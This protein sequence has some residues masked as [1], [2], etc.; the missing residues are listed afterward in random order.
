MVHVQ[1]PMTVVYG[2]HIRT[3]GWAGAYGKCRTDLWAA[4]GQSE[5]LDCMTICLC[6]IMI[7]LRQRIG[8]VLDHELDV[9]F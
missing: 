7:D 1:P 2:S 9:R 6:N 3:P 4:I 8:Q 5:H